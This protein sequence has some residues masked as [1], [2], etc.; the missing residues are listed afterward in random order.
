VERSAPLP[1]PRG[2]CAAVSVGSAIYVLGGDIGENI[3]PT[4]GTLKFDG[5]HGVWSR[6]ASMPEARSEFDARGQGQASCSCTARRLTPGVSLHPCRPP[7][8]DSV[9]V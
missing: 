1:E 6:V 3:D 4:D 8:M 9:Q 2:S 7:N 5:A